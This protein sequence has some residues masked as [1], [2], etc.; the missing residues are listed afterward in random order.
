MG[1]GR[2]GQRAG[3]R[4]QGRRGAGLEG[5][6]TISLVCCGAGHQFKA[7]ATCPLS[8]RKGNLKEGGGG[9]SVAFLTWALPSPTV[10]PVTPAAPPVS[11]AGLHVS[12]RHCR[13]PLWLHARLG[14]HR[15]YAPGTTIFK[16]FI[17]LRLFL[18]PR[19]TRVAACKL[20]SS[21]FLPLAPN[22][23]PNPYPTSAVLVRSL[24]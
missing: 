23:N 19:T 20:A 4:S 13:G 5:Q 11:G 6:F 18:L 7:A 3:A 22:P 12:R 9:V 10:P 14:Y 15:L 17:L 8:L 1:I 21:F 16:L 24:L 2:R